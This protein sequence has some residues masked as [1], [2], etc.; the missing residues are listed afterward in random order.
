MMK[1]PVLCLSFATV[2]L[3]ASGGLCISVAQDELS[4]WTIYQYDLQPSNPPAVWVLSDGNT[5]ATQ[6]ENNDL[7]MMLNNQAMKSYVATGT[8]QVDTTADDD[9][10]GI[11]FGWRD[12]SHFYYMAWRQEDQGSSI[13]GFM[14]KKI[15]APT[16]SDL[17]NPDLW[18][19]TDTVNSTVLAS[20]LGDG[21]GWVDFVQYDYV[22]I[23]QPGVFH[24]T[25]SE[26][27]DILWDV[28]VEDGAYTSGQFGLY[29]FSQE[30]SRFT[31]EVT[32]ISEAPALSGW[33]LPVLILALAVVS[34]FGIVRYRSRAR[35]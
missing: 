9:Q 35:A 1:K 30:D 12:S 15:A 13:E 28:R 14:I 17:T 22:L 10:I 34:A 21:K 31:A 7:S 18:W 26:G 11:A 32:Q 33:G 16:A 8:F 27:D 3:L 29:C 4:S 5:V 24:V 19:A 20:D 25:V 23:F 2:L 6:T